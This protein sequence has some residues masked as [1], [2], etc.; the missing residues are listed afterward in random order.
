MPRLCVALRTT[1]ASPHCMSPQE[2]LHGSSPRTAPHRFTLQTSLLLTA[3]ARSPSLHCGFCLRLSFDLW[4]HKI[5]LRGPSHL[6]RVL[7]FALATTKRYTKFNLFLSNTTFKK[8]K[9]GKQKHSNSSLKHQHE[10]D[11]CSL[12]HMPRPCSVCVLATD[13]PTCGTTVI[14]VSA[15]R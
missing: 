5:G 12:R 8:K 1:E 4:P 14:T 10:D 7:K 9:S 6:H 3:S 2:H 15:Q 11:V 13:P